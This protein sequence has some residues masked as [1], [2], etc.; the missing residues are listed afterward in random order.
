VSGYGFS[1]IEKDQTT[2]GF[3]RWPQ[4]LKADRICSL[5]HAWKACSDTNRDAMIFQIS[6]SVDDD[7]GFVSGCSSTME[8]RSGCFVSGHGFSRADHVLK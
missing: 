6:F 4:R 2:V 3:S 5:R 7:E 1:R 8:I